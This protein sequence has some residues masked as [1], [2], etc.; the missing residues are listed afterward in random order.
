MQARAKRM[1]IFAPTYILGVMKFSTLMEIT[2]A[3]HLSSYVESPFKWRGG[4]FLV[5]PPGSLKS[6]LA[7]VVNTYRGVVAVSDINIP[8]LIAM[9]EDM[10]SLAIRTLVF[11]DWGKIYK[12]NPAVAANIEGVIMAYAEE[13]FRR[14]AFQPQS[15]STSL[16]RCTILG[17]MTPGLFDFKIERWKTDGF[18]RRF[19]FARYSVNGMD[20]LDDALLNQRLAKFHNGFDTRT[21][22]APLGIPYELSK[23]N[24]ALI[25]D[26]THQIMYRQGNI[27]MLQ[28][29]LSVL[30]WKHGEKSAVKIFKDFMP[31]LSKDGGTLELEELI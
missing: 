2:A 21:P 29:I 5:A 25:D 28:K 4:L 10:Q 3:G 26:A 1:D 17:A 15:I 24:M 13:G 20:I 23:S 9:K 19:V 11:S 30:K 12:R 7:E 14:A 8:P 22:V 18:Y 16:A 6:T 31:C 27:A